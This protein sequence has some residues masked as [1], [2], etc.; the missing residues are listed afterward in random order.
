VKRRIRRRAAPKVRRCAC[1]VARAEAKERMAGAGG[2]MI[3]GAKDPAEAK[4][5]AR[6][7]RALATVP[8][9]HR[10]CAGCEAEDTARRAPAAGVIAPGGASA[11]APKSAQKAVNALGPGR[12]LSAPDRAFYEPRLN[13]D[14]SAVRLHENAAADT[15]ARAMDAQAFTLGTDIAFAKGERRRGGVELLAHELAHAAERAPQVRRRLWVRAPLAQIPRPGGRGLRQTIGQTVQTYLDRICSAGHPRVERNGRIRL[16]EN[17]CADRRQS[18]LGGC[19]CMCALIRSRNNWRIIVRDTPHF[20]S[21]PSNRWDDDQAARTR[22]SGG[23]GGLIFVPSPNNPREYGAASITGDIV[24]MENWELLQH[25]ICGHARLADTGSHPEEEEGAVRQGHGTVVPIT[26]AMND[27]RPGA[28][29][30]HR[31]HLV[32]HPYCG[33]SFYRER[34]ATDWTP[35]SHIG[36]CDELREAYLQSAREDYPKDLRFQRSF[37]RGEMLP[38]RADRPSG[39]IP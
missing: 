38:F 8:T 20:G 31:G 35:S 14:L 27:Q 18:T 39:R 29:R 22:R 1:N 30:P 6:A 17:F 33:E 12:P 2:L 9:V 3:G 16:D 4:A 15:A 28:R 36:E 7:T 37:G 34:G 23:T 26:N 32:Q 21:N 19:D 25:E 10:K 11:P 13:A 24:A 5:A